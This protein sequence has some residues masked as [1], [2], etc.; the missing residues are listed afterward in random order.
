MRR[1]DMKAYKHTI[2]A[3]GLCAV[4]GLFPACSDFLEEDPKG[5]MTNLSAFTER[6]DLEGSINA[7]YY[8]I[9]MATMYISDAT[10]V[11]AGDD[12]TSIISKSQFGDFDQFVANDANAMLLNT[13]IGCWAPWWNIIK[14]SNFIINGVANT[15][16]V[17]QEEINMAIGEGRFWRA[18]A[19]FN[20]VRAWGPLP[21]IE[22][23]ELDM[24]IGTSTER[25]V[26]DFIVADL[27]YAEENLPAQFSSAPWSMN[28]LNSIASQAAA[29]AALAQVYLTMAGWPLNGGAEYYALAAGK[30]KE[31]IDG[32][33]NGTYP[34]RLFDEYW[35]IYSRQYNLAQVEN[36]LPVHFS[37]N[38]GNQDSSQAARTPTGIPEEAGGWSDVRAEVKFWL[39]YP[40][41]PRKKAVFGDVYYHTRDQKVVPWFYENVTNCNNPYYLVDAFCNDEVEY[42]QTIACNQQ[43]NYWGNKTAVCIRLSQV[44]LWY[45]EAVG[46]SGQGDKALAIELLNT[47]R[48]RADGHYNDASYNVYPSTLSYE[49]LAEAAYNEHGW[50]IAGYYR[51]NIATRYHDQRRMNRLKDHFEYRLR[52]PEIEVTQQWLKENPDKADM[53][54]GPVYVKER[55][56]ISGAW[57]D[58]RAYVEYPSTDKTL[59][60]NLKR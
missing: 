50:E 47:V 56:A 1:I 45:A 59:A 29:K 24:N 11:I 36:L 22:R 34:Y 2:A 31:V 14:A 40:A 33:D 9:K 57:D 35:K 18:F 48:R 3:A 13:T 17:S 41:G 8:Q 16:E 43:T 7:L 20:L 46:R 21:I 42:D 37:R 32:C 38:F 39:D 30:A 52:N 58:S 49:E 15:P 25:E 6:S 54:T 27:R 10:P 23:D 26:Y 55:L 53:V 44:Y 5:Q 28:G 51:G 12:L 60:P 4:L 19:Y